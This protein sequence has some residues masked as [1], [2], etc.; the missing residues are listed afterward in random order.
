MI[1][2]TLGEYIGV[3]LGAHG[4]IN[5]KR[6]YNERALSKY[7]DHFIKEETVQTKEMLIQD[8]LIFG[9]RKLSGV[10]I[11]EIEEKYKINLFE[12]YPNLQEKID[13]GLVE[14]DHDYLKLTKQGLFLG[15]QVFMV[16]I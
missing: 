11:K 8:E 5:G 9:L 10:N 13:L 16:F 12:T 6:T 15:N 2:W 14:I 4:F 3:G 7:L 1:Y